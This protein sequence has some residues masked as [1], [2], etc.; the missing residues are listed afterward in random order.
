MKGGVDMKRTMCLVGII[1]FFLPVLAAWQAIGPEGGNVRAVCVSP[2]NDN[3]VYLGT[4]TYPA[5]I[6]KSSNAGGSWT[7][8]GYYTGYLYCMAIDPSENLYC[9]Y[10]GRVYK[11]TDG[12][13]TWT[14]GTIAS[15]AVYDLAVHP[16]NPSI[17]YG[18]GYHYISSG[19]YEMVCLK[20][21]D[22]GTS[23]STTS[24]IA[25]GYTY[26]RAVAI[27][28][29]NPNVIYV[30]GNDNEDSTYHPRVFKSTDGGSTFTDVT[31]G[32]GA[33]YYVYSLAVHPTSSIV[34]VGTYTDGIWRSADGGS[35]WTKVS[36]LYYNY[37][38]ATSPA[39][40]DLVLSGGSS[41]IYRSTDAGV[42]W[43][44]LTTGLYGSTYY[45]LD[46]SHSN[47]SSL[48]AGNT[49]G[50]FKSTNMGTTWWASN[51]NMYCG[52]I[53][54][55]GIAPSAPAT[56]Y[57]E[58]EGVGVYKTTNNGTSWTLLPTPSTCGALC[59]FAVHN[60]DANMVFGLEGSG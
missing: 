37:Q 31:M 26:G 21:T 47:A 5:K 7:F 41:S 1:G 53:L 17:V 33:G 8:M 56:M 52:D 16:S 2:V 27:D 46:I 20:S 19:N 35:S 42:T 28:P 6:L 59:A 14:Y 11:S 43:T 36:T 45:G 22:A 15:T 54:D 55:F 32:T 50:F 4:Y 40:P 44:S 12:G 57:T 60:T 58:F 51:T 13:A 29:S 48:F 30:G 9:G 3:N 39:N 23:W 49:S 24:I 25:G 10:Y 38:M 34:Y 18:A